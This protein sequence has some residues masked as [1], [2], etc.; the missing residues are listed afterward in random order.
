MGTDG[1]FDINPKRADAGGFGLTSGGLFMI[2]GKCCEQV[3]VVDACACGPCCFTDQSRIRI[4]W[5]LIDSGNAQNRCCCDDP[6]MLSNAIEIPLQCSAWVPPGYCTGCTLTGLGTNP[7][8]SNCPSNV[9]KGPRWVGYDLNPSGVSCNS[10]FNATVHCDCSG[11]D[12]TFWSVT[13]GASSLGGS[14][15]KCG[16][17]FSVCIPSAP[18]NCRHASAI[19]S[20]QQ[21]HTICSNNNPSGKNPHVQVEIE[22]LDN[23]VCMDEQ[24][25]CQ[26]GT[27]DNNGQCAPA[28][29][30]QT[31]GSNQTPG[32]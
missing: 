22:V 19:V 30:S 8:Q 7:S 10:Y 15:G 5:Q 13:V 17:L 11:G 2:C 20:E 6:G 1:E 21:N 3:V 28:P 16:V 26:M 9:I 14:A 27:S 18:G 24:G 25:Q 29:G 31:P 4:T 32:I 23:P 12:T